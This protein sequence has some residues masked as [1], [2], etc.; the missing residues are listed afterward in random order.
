MKRIILIIM[1]VTVLVV[2]MTLFASCNVKV[3]N[4]ASCACV[5]DSYACCACDIK[6]GS[7]SA[8]SE[9]ENAPLG[10]AVREVEDQVA[11]E[12]ITQ[13]WNTVIV[14]GDMPFFW[15]RCNSN[16]VNVLEADWQREFWT[17]LDSLQGENIVFVGCKRKEANVGFAS[18]NDPRRMTIKMIGE[19]TE[20]YFEIFLVEDGRVLITYSKYDGYYC[21]TDLNAV[22]FDDWKALSSA[23]LRTFSELEK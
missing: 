17:L 8:D 5:A 6:G 10:E 16:P 9:I 2:L 3:N 15:V 22:D 20:E 7:E 11:Y 21:Y 13:I 12:A 4:E 18:H 19:D 1:V 23:S 14:D